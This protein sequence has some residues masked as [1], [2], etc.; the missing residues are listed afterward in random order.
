MGS[1]DCES[2][3]ARETGPR[4]GCRCEKWPDECALPCPCPLPCRGHRPNSILVFGIVD[5]THAAK[6]WALPVTLLAATD[7]RLR[8]DHYHGDQSPS[9]SVVCPTSMRYPSGSRI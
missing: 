3:T 7:A 6:V 8:S 1:G 2:S 9:E 5:G 4:L